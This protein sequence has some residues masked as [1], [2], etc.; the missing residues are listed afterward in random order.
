MTTDERIRRGPQYYQLVTKAVT[1]SIIAP[2]KF[3]NISGL[4]GDIKSIH[5]WASI[6]IT[7]VLN[8]QPD[9]S[10]R[11]ATPPA[12]IVMILLVHS[13]STAGCFVLFASASVTSQQEDWSNPFYWLVQKKSSRVKNSSATTVCGF[14]TS[15]IRV[16]WHLL[17]RHCFLTYNFF[18][19]GNKTVSSCRRLG[20]KKKRVLFGEIK[21]GRSRL[22]RKR[23]SL[24]LEEGY[25]RRLIECRIW[26]LTYPEWSPLFGWW[27]P[28]T[29]SSS[30]PFLFFFQQQQ[31]GGAISSCV[32]T[33]SISN[34]KKINDR[35]HEEQSTM[36]IFLPAQW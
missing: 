9:D 15:Q 21:G 28:V 31:I 24:E 29:K 19:F 25:W 7:V 17:S 33:Y 36:T 22:E 8:N 14:P 3:E 16:D 5:E 35:R 18:S 11:H 6:I 10:I 1:W 30:P 12:L 4:K 13:H 23:D 34:W 26:Q 2:N 20:L 32:K 27:C